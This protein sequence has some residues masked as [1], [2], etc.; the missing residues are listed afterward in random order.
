VTPT[1]RYCHADL[2]QT[3]VDLGATPLANSYIAR[4]DPSVLAAERSFPLNVMVCTACWLVQTTETPPAD[5]IFSHDYAYLS[6]WSQGWVEHARHY[7]QTMIARLSL[8]ANSKVVEVASNDG[9]L[10]QHFVAAGIPVLGV[11]PAGHA[12]SLAEARGVP[13]QVAFFN[14]HTAAVLLAEGHAADLIAANNVLAH[15]PDIGAFVRG[16]RTLLKPDGVATFEFP[17]LARLL[18]QVQ[19]DT[20]YHEHYSYLSLTFVARL[21]CDAGLEVFDIDRLTTHG[22]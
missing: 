18:D 15:V 22:G 5:A 14:E 3:L 2:S 13:T 6:S 10:L 20:I 1:C 7:A 11:E 8:S 21:M 17:H 12:A 9:Y 4:D 16:F 19:F